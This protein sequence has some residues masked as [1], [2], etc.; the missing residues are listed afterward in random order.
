MKKLLALLLLIATPVLAGQTTP[1]GVNGNLI[2]NSNNQWGAS[3]LSTDG[4]SKL[5]GGSGAAST[6]TLEST[7]GA[8]T[9]DSILFKTGSQ[10]TVETIQG[11]GNILF[12]SLP[13][14]YIL[15]GL[16]TP[17]SSMVDATY[18]QLQMANAGIGL[19]NYST[20]NSGSELTFFNSNTSTYGNHGTVPN[21]RN[22][23][24]IAFDPYITSDYSQDGY[25][26]VNVD[27]SVT[28]G[29]VPTQ[30]VFDT[31]PQGNNIPIIFGP[32]GYIGIGIPLSGAPTTDPSYP[33]QIK[34]TSAAVYGAQI[35]TNQNS[36]AAVPLQLQNTSNGSSAV[37]A[38]NL[39]NDYSGYAGIIEINGHT[40]VGGAGADGL[41]LQSTNGN[42]AIY[43]NGGSVILGTS[44]ILSSAS[45]WAGYGACYTTNGKFGHCTTALSG[46]GTCTCVGN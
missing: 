8:G 24:C 33:L 7:S 35:T 13:Y 16:T 20:F 10:S 44:T 32:L 6:L 38:I 5:I 31:D 40:N 4:T 39:G 15:T 34:Y 18:M 14:H 23:G 1:P 17:E 26:C 41:T 22:I 37:T 27:G 43:A 9:T 2:Y 21:G 12:K 29:H 25:L 19:F 30:F 28:S 36:A 11:N 3:T 45:S 46:S 42:V